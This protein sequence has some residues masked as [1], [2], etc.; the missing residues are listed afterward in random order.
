MREPQRVVGR[1]LKV[2]E[3]TVAH[4]IVFVIVEPSSPEVHPSVDLRR[5]R[6]SWSAPVSCVSQSIS[7]S[8]IGSTCWV[9]GKEGVNKWMDVDKQGW[10]V[11]IHYIYKHDRKS[12][13][14]MT[15]KRIM[16]Q[17]AKAQQQQLHSPHA[18]PQTAVI[19]LIQT[20]VPIS[21]IRQVTARTRHK[22]W[23]IWGRVIIIPSTQIPIGTGPGDIIQRRVAD[24]EIPNIAILHSIVVAAVAG[25]K[26]S[27]GEKNRLG[28]ICKRGIDGP[29][30]AYDRRDATWTQ[31]L[32]IN[33]WMG[34][35]WSAQT[36]KQTDRQT[37]RLV[38]IGVE[39][40][41]GGRSGHQ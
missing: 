20:G 16:H 10:R 4:V 37:D 8:A 31:M 1:S 33:G 2:E 26:I 22:S 6:G 40:G 27:V 39:K 3:I 19:G 18:N 9:H 12:S 34:Q 13:H 28:R 17:W 23:H 24:R 32:D 11:L 36:N 21:H 5:T 29:V 14:G 41:E 15:H 7:Q 35:K 30:P 38:E 25:A